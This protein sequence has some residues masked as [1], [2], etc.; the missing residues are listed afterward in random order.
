MHVATQ[1]QL[2]SLNDLALSSQAQWAAQAINDILDNIEELSHRQKMHFADK[3]R[4][5]A[6]T[7]DG[8]KTS[9]GN[10]NTIIIK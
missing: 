8:R 7:V 1:K 2:D 9:G 5:F 10:Q 3:L 4:S 6:D